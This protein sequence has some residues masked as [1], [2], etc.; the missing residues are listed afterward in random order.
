V[1]GRLQSS[2]D[3]Y[4]KIHTTKMPD[5]ATQPYTLHTDGSSHGNPGPAG[6][7]FVLVDSAGATVAEQAIPLGTTTVG[8][9]E[10]RGLIAGLHEALN[11]GVRSIRVRSDSEFMCRQL[12]GRY[13]VRTEAIKPLYAWAKRLSERFEQFEITHCGREHN[14]RADEL[15]NQAS[16]ASRNGATGA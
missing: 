13:R 11:Q 6:A 8:V 3:N 2:A 1:T 12:Q 16:R 14:E 7:A 10:Y 15:A 5:T 9:A 4:R